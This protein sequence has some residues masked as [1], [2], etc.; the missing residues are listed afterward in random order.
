MGTTGVGQSD[1]GAFAITTCAAG[2]RFEPDGSADAA[3]K[4][5]ASVLQLTVVTTLRGKLHPTIGEEVI[6]DDGKPEIG[7]TSDFATAGNFGLFDVAPSIA[8]G[9]SASVPIRGLSLTAATEVAIVGTEQRAPAGNGSLGRSP[10]TIGVFAAVAVVDDV[11]LNGA[12][13]AA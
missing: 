10:D 1:I 4:S 12:V 13:T 2:T 3:T 11:V 6:S 8:C 5:L 9:L 7:S